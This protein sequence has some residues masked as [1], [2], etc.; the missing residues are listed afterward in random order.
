MGIARAAAFL[1]ALLCGAAA[2]TLFRERDLAALGRGS[3]SCSPWASCSRRPR[4][5][6]SSACATPPRRGSSRTTRP[7]RS[8]R[9]ATCVLDGEN[10]YGHDYRRSG[11]ERFYTRDGSV[12][13]RVREREVAL[14]HFAYFPG[15][16]LSAAAWRVLPE[17]FDDYRLLVLLA[18]LGG[19]R[20]RA[21]VPRRRSAGGSRSARVLVCNPMAV[22]SR[23][24][25]PERPAQPAAARARVRAGHARRASAGPRRA[26]PAPCCSSSSR[27]SRSR[28][29]RS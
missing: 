26:S 12:S 21:G 25:R 18:T 13:E 27:S 4:R 19:A 17:P 22:R 1:A 20:R 16:P 7:T 29:S 10:P 28:S 2:L 5:C 8:S 15:A 9:A 24:V 11:L 23:L 6:S 3:R 14:R